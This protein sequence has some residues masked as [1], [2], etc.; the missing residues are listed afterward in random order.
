MGMHNP[1]DDRKLK[2]M[3][4]DYF[5]KAY[6]LIQKE[7]LILFQITHALC[8]L[9][10]IE[11]MREQSFEFGFFDIPTPLFRKA[12]IAHQNDSFFNTA[13]GHMSL[14]QLRLFLD[15]LPIDCTLVDKDNKVIYFNRPKDRI[16]PRSPSII[17]RDVRN[18]HP[19]DSVDVVDAI[20]EAFKNN[21]RNEAR[22]W[23]EMRG[24]FLYIRYVALR[25]E[26]GLY[27]GTLEI[28]QE[29]SDIRALKGQRRLLQWDEAL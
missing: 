4:G 25:D 26:A 15:H 17:G 27:Q 16:F 23:I 18:C 10:D 7:E 21:Q 9:E 24:K 20:I 19:A 22:F 28:S 8:P 14:E 5:F 11:A 12:Q 6:G 2:Q 29:V 13:T 1:Q 3:I